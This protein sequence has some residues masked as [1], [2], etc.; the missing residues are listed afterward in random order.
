MEATTAREDY[1]CGACQNRTHKEQRSAFVSC[2]VLQ[3]ASKTR[4][5]RYNSVGIRALLLLCTR[6]A[7]F[8]ASN[9]PSDTAQ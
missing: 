8:N 7:E 1:C 9:Q 3:H 6:A 5:Q 2:W 4:K